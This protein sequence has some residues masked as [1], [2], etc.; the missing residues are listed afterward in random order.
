ML[1]VANISRAGRIAPIHLH[2]HLH[3]HTHRHHFPARHVQKPHAQGWPGQAQVRAQEMLGA[4]MFLQKWFVG[5]SGICGGIHQPTETWRDE[6]SERRKSCTTRKAQ[7]S[8]CHNPLSLIHHR[9]NSH[10]G[11]INPLRLEDGYLIP[12]SYSYWSHKAAE[13]IL[14]GKMPSQP[15]L[16]SE[17][18]RGPGGL[19]PTRV[20]RIK[21]V[22]QRTSGSSLSTDPSSLSLILGLH[23][24]F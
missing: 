20:Q 9:F 1:Q 24:K 13:D 2:N 22:G 15:L 23:S 7:P 19:L 3:K 12:K 10:L 18:P 5:C 8:S 21:P 16:L 11:K 17:C 6:L 14:M 4:K